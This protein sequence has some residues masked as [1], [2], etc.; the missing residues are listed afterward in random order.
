MVLPTMLKKPCAGGTLAPATGSATRRAFG[1][2]DP[3]EGRKCTGGSGGSKRAGCVAEGKTQVTHSLTST[4][5]HAWSK[6]VAE[7]DCEKTGAGSKDSTRAKC[8]IM[9]V[10][11]PKKVTVAAAAG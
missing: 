6:R 3:S 2:C 9:P 1:Q 11:V 4:P 8:A 10:P 7:R 5:D